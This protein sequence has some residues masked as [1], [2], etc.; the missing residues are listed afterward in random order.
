MNYKQTI[1]ELED[2]IKNNYKLYYKQFNINN[3]I[4]LNKYIDIN[5]KELKCYSFN[6]YLIMTNA[7]STNDKINEYIIDNF[8]YLNDNIKNKYIYQYM[9]HLNIILNKINKFNEKNNIIEYNIDDNENSGY[10]TA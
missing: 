10:N 4:S 6:H 8:L 3:N 5:I 9:N 2:E 1:K 7:F